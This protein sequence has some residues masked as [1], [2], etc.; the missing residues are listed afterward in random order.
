[1]RVEQ[2]VTVCQHVVVGGRDLAASHPAGQRGAVLDHQ[3]V[4]RHVVDR[5]GDD[6]VDRT[7]EIVVGLPGR[8]IYEVEVDVVEARGAGFA[9]RRECP[10]RRVHP[11][12]HRQHVRSDGLHAERHPGEPH[13]AQLLEEL[14]RSGFRIRLGGD[15]G[16]AGQRRNCSRTASS[17]APRPVP[18]SSDGVPPPTNTVSTPVAQPR[19]RQAELSAHRPSHPSGFAPPSSAGV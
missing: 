17:T 1:M 14:R 6:R 9:G 5:G 2:L 8:A 19:R 13:R 4:C 18:P 15:L 3:R 10:A 11:I 7:A 16:G 12:Q